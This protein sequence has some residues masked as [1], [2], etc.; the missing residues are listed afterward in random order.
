MSLFG[1]DFKGNSFTVVEA[2]Y[3][4]GYDAPE[5][6]RIYNGFSNMDEAVSFA[7][8]KAKDIKSLLRVNQVDAQNDEMPS[9]VVAIVKK[10]RY[11]FTCLPSLDIRNTPICF[12]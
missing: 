10:G 5:Y 6:R 4:D 7:K 11:V 8:D 12:L 9:Y 1:Y 2:W 3:A